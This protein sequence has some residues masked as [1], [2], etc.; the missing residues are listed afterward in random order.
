MLIG[1]ETSVKVILVAEILDRR[2]IM[3]TNTLYHTWFLRI[4]ELRPGQ[5]I[6]QVRNFVW[7]ITGIYQSRSVY[8]LL[9]PDRR[10]GSQFGEIGEYHPEVEPAVG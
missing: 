3:P 1:R 6:T 9:E 8:L 7:L 2:I 10:E 5:R 4:K